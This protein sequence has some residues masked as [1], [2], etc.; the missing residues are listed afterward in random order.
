[1][2]GSTQIL[3][4]PR[5]LFICILFISGCTGLSHRISEESKE[6]HSSSE[7][8]AIISVLVSQNHT[9]KTIK[10]VGKITFLEKEITSR[11][12]WVASAPDKIR[13]TLSSV[14]G[15]PMISAASDGQWFYLFS[16]ATGD[17]YKKRPTN[18]NMKR[19]F[20]ISIKSEDIVNILLGRI[21]VVEYDSVGLI[22][23][24]SIKGLS[25]INSKSVE[26]SSL[27]KDIK[28]NK[29]SSVLFLKNKWGN[30]REKI[31]LN[32]TQDAHKIEMFDSS[33]ALVYRLELIRMQEIKSYR[34]PYRLK[35]S[36]DDGMGFQLDLDRYWADAAVSPSVFT[37]APPK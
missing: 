24:R 35:V 37:L 28:G 1:M 26:V 25:A 30:V 13:I 15:H 8:K 14:S 21:P 31:Y 11:I 27:N 16:H 20:S 2:N 7:A 36:N 4:L 32:D 17:F 29:N 12:A 22:E 34:V 33:G 6:F 5:I 19:F 18:F 3:Q 9:L 23:D 10:G